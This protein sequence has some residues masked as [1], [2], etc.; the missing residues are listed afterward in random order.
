MGSSRRAF[1]VGLLAALGIRRKADAA[2]YVWYSEGSGWCVP[3]GYCAWPGSLYKNKRQYYCPTQGSCYPTS[4]VV[5]YWTG[6]CCY[7]G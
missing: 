4:N 3:D 6:R 2:Y 7:A 1:V 5:P